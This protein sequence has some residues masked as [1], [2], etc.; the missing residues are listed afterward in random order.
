MRLV[1]T[2]YRLREVSCGFGETHVEDDF[3]GS[4]SSS[5]LLPPLPHEPLVDHAASPMVK[6]TDVPNV[7][8]LSFFQALVEWKDCAR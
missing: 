1:V 5:L 8:F 3:L 2:S 7:N 4:P 6:T